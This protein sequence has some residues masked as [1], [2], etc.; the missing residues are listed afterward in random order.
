MSRKLTLPTDSAV[1]KDV[2]LY[3][4]CYTYFPAALAGVAIHSKAGND[5]H[6]P[7]ETLHHARGKSMDHADCIARHS[8]DLADMLAAIERHATPDIVSA[9]DILTEARALSWRALAWH[10]ELEERFGEA[11]LAPAARLPSTDAAYLS[12]PKVGFFDF[13]QSGSI[14]AQGRASLLDPF[15]VDASAPLARLIDPHHD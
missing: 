5:K 6:N 14:L 15:P 11:P 8:M 4:G 10:Q 12:V 2:P 1:R 3:S 13:P 7:G 9:Q